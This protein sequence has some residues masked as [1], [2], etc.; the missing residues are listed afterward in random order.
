MNHV[1]EAKNK[2]KKKGRLRY[3]II[4]LFICFLFCTGTPA[5][6]WHHDR[7]QTVRIHCLPQ[8]VPALEVLKP[9]LRAALDRIAAEL[10]TGKPDSLDLYLAPDRRTFQQLTGGR[11]PEWG[12][13]CAF[14]AQGRIYVHLEQRD[15]EALKRTLVHELA[16]VILYRQTQGIHLPRWFNEGM[17][18]WLAREW[19]YGQSMEMGLA[20]LVDGFHPLKEVE[21][22][23]GFPES[24][25]R[26]AYAESFSAVLLLQRLGGRGVWPDLLEALR[27][28]SSFERALIEVVG[29][30][31]QAFEQV[32]LAH[33]HQ[34]FNPLRLLFD[35][36][37]LWLG[38]IGLAILAYIGTR[39]RARRL[40][41]AWEEEESQEWEE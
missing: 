15:P 7:E 9:V 5:R 35:T 27:R 10:G 38:I 3:L 20:A 21:S 41:R 33:L 34:E 36:G 13:G 39:I 29:M 18:M 40:K 28:Q 2:D 37:L 16:H 6:E 19:H 26:R 14:P 24:E 17:A 32:W 22:M 31:S 1:E 11:I 8:N 12:A 4:S 25:A 23:L 30:N